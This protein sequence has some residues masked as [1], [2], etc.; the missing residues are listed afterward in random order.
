ME[1]VRLTLNHV[2]LAYV[3]FLGCALRSCSLFLLLVLFF[4]FFLL[5]YFR[6]VWVPT[7]FS[8]FPCVFYVQ[9]VILMPCLTFVLEPLCFFTHALL[10]KALVDQYHRKQAEDAKKSAGKTKEPSKGKKGAP[11]P[12]SAKKRSKRSPPEP[13]TSIPVASLVSEHDAGGESVEWEADAV[14]EE[15]EVDGERQFLVQWAKSN[16]G[17]QHPPEWCDEEQLKDARDLIEA[18]RASNKGD[19]AKSGASAEPQKVG[20]LL[21]GYGDALNTGQGK[22]M[23]LSLQQAL[24]NRASRR[25]CAAGMLDVKGSIAG[26]PVGTGD[27]T[28]YR[29]GLYDKEKDKFVG[30]GT[31]VGGQNSVIIGVQYA[32]SHWQAVTLPRETFSQSPEQALSATSGSVR[33][34]KHDSFPLTEFSLDA[35]LVQD[36]EFWG[37]AG[38]WA[39]QYVKDSRVTIKKP[40]LT[41]SQT[42]RKNTRRGSGN[43]PYN[44]RALDGPSEG[45]FVVSDAESAG[46]GDE[47]VETKKKTTRRKGAKKSPK[48]RTKR[49]RSEE[50]PATQVTQPERIQPSV[51]PNQVAKV[52]TARHEARGN[53]NVRLAAVMAMQEQKIIMLE[54]QV[55]KRKEEE[56]LEKIMAL[57]PE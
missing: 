45:A 38:A 42:P 10:T 55:R 12:A 36:L 23:R 33:L 4:L 27:A 30:P 19:D 52:A 40:P 9:F 35:D 44:F 51:P 16:T 20:K 41:S 37:R 47:D 6:T 1:N 39:D 24:G 22:I 26:E 49:E 14:L 8:H 43:S 54:E 7:L 2:V 13:P 17:L 21:E 29:M 56:S 28:F 25:Y 34:F 46:S 57:F 11:T 53:P 15:R 50:E 18:Y 48:K 5:S 32:S 3:T 31:V